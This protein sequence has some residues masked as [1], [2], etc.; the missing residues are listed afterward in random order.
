VKVETCLYSIGFDSLTSWKKLE[1]GGDGMY[2]EF[3]ENWAPARPEQIRRI[4]KKI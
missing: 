2:K 4:Y 1:V 3:T